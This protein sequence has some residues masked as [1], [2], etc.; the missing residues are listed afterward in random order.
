VSSGTAGAVARV[1]ALAQQFIASAKII[2]AL[3]GLMRDGALST[4]AGKA[5]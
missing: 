4:F 3:L 1:A 2:W 5:P